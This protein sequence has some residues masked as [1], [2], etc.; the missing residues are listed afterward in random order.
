MR[1]RSKKSTN[2]RK[3]VPRI[4]ADELQW[5]GSFVVGSV[6]QATINC[7]SDIKKDASHI[8][9]PKNGQKRNGG[10]SFYRQKVA[11]YTYYTLMII[12]T[13]FFYYD[14]NERNDTICDGISIH[15]DLIR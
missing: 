14:G 6:K 5:M 10:H 8:R 1:A 11:N 3:T 13:I 15:R 12:H 7:N 2:P 4:L 9:N